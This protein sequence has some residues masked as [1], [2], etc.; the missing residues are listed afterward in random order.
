MEDTRTALERAEKM[1]GLLGIPTSRPED[2]RLDASVVPA[3]LLEVVKRIK[4]TR[5]GYLST[6]T[7]LDHPEPESRESKD[8]QWRHIQD[9]A[10]LDDLETSGAV[11]ILYHFCNGAAVLSLRLLAS[12]S[13]A[14]IPTISTQFSS[15]TLYEMELAEM[16]GVR[17]QGIPQ[18]HLLL[19]E[20]WPKNV[21]PLRKSFHGLKDSG[22]TRRQA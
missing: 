3:N 9:E 19:P 10:M 16:F 21:Y 7:G 2:F 15:A 17:I 14:T 8:R 18:E 11:E 6:I 12:Y 22:D 13:H 20:D 1:L 4:E 5:W